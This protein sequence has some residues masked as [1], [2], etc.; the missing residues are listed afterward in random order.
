MFPHTKYIY[1][2]HLRNSLIFES[3]ISYKSSLSKKQMC[4]VLKVTYPMKY[5]DN[6]QFIKKLFD[7][8]S[9]SLLTYMHIILPNW[10]SYSH[11]HYPRCNLSMPVFD[12]VWILSHWVCLR[13]AHH[14]W[15][16]GC[17]FVGDSLSMLR[18]N[19]FVA[20]QHDCLCLLE[21][22]VTDVQLRSDLVILLHV[23]T[24]MWECW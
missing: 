7:N 21:T 10:S 12:P 8:Q 23:F 17:V 3:V 1:H 16:L 15:G 9:I 22:D 11:L 20:W 19:S 14:R 4:A 24:G 5:G 6:I 2:E 18:T 13:W